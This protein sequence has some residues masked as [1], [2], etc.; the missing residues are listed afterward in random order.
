MLEKHA[1][2]IAAHIPS[3][4]VLVELG[5]GSATKTSII[6]QALLRRC[7]LGQFPIKFEPSDAFPFPLIASFI[8]M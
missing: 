6:L 5:C 8:V 4:A 2:E 3:G 1:D 7:V